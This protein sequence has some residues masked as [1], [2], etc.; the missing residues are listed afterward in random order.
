[1]KQLLND[2]ETVPQAGGSVDVGSDVNMLNF[3][4]SLNVGYVN[5]NNLSNKVEY[6]ANI[7]KTYN[8]HV[9]GVGESCLTDNVPSS[10]V[11][12]WGYD[13]V[14]RDSPDN[15]RKPGVAV[16]LKL[17]LKFEAFQCSVDN[18]VIIYLSGFDFYVLNL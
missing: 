18:L 9:F 13:I 17:G 11:S 5:L 3:S 6:V 14:R 2:G 1:M 4:V 16:Y 7:L 8:F 15:I 10:F 12:I